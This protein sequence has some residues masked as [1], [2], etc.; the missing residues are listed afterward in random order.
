MWA[1]LIKLRADDGTV[2]Q[3]RSFYDNECCQFDGSITE[4]HHTQ[5]IWSRHSQ[6]PGDNLSSV[7]L[8]S[9]S[10][11]QCPGHPSQG[12]HHHHHHHTLPE[13]QAFTWISIFLQYFSSRQIFR[14]LSFLLRGPEEWIFIETTR[15]GKNALAKLRKIFFLH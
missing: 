8:S 3:S 5:N 10:P 11:Q 12:H 15:R 4:C 13:G 14:L 2:S 7:S 1:N 9:L 6:S